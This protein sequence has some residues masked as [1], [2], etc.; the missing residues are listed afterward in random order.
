MPEFVVRALKDIPKATPS[1][2]FWSGMGTLDGVVSSWRK[3]LQKLFELAGVQ[4][5]HAHRFRDTFATELLLAGVPIER[6]AVLLGH[7]S[8]KVTERYY[9]AWTADRQRQVEADLRRAWGRDPIAAM[10]KKHTLQLRGQN[11]AVN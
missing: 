1:R 7:R 2:F 9:S 5:G 6:V 3:R 4:A 11:I 10:G 8:V